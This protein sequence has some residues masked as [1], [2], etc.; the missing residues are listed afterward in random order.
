MTG[1]DA[2]EVALP[3]YRVSAET[4]EEA[5]GSFRARIDG[6]VVPGHDED[7]VT[8]AIDAARGLDPSGVEH[9]AVGSSTRPQPGTLAAGTIAR[10]LG[11]AGSLRTVALG[12]SWKAGL[13]ALDV[14]L[15]LEGRGLAVASDAP[16]GTP[17][18]PADHVLGAGA[19]AALTGEGTVAK[20]L[21]A[22]HYADARLPGKFDADGEVAD[23]ELGRYAAEGVRQAVERVVEGALEG[24]GLAPADVAH[25][26][27]PQEDVKVGWRLGGRLG[28]DDERR[29]NGWVVNRLG[30]AGAATPVVGLAAALAASDPGDRVLATAY[31]YGEG[32]GALL[33]EA[34]DGAAEV[35]LDLDALVEATAPLDV[36]AYLALRGGST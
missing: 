16:R 8:M 30:F 24:A 11:I 26:V 22:A 1:I 15:E 18:E 27:L 23:L 32:A 13:E 7:A 29:A 20:L 3:R 33:F 19:A 25:V 12:A 5:L 31:G 9:L 36:P 34:T 6:K 28:F 35:G 14:A 17:G 2:L 4:Y 10:S 21:G